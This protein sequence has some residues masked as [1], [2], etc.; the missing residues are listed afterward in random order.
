MAISLVLLAL[1]SSVVQMETLPL[2]PLGEDLAQV[3]TAR[4]AAAT[5]PAETATLI[6]RHTV[7]H[8]TAMEAP[9]PPT[10]WKDETVRFYSPARR[11]NDQACQRQ[12]FTVRV[13]KTSDGGYSANGHAHATQEVSIAPDCEL[14]PTAW[15]AV[16]N[17]GL[18]IED[19][20]SALLIISNTR[21]AQDAEYR[22]SCISHLANYACPA[23]ARAVLATLPLAGAYLSRRRHGQGVG[24][25]IARTGDQIAGGYWQIEVLTTPS[26]DIIMTRA[27]PAPF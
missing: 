23:D 21:P 16:V 13:Q 18:K 1:V 15:F 6:A 3:D 11:L 8:R 19:A 7:R 27:I 14:D 12:F 9:A 26:P 17:P 5:L 2:S 24:I 4:L 20:V 10:G 22:L 25:E